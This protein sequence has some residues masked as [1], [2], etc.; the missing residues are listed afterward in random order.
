[1]E[2]LD[3]HQWLC[4]FTQY[5]DKLELYLTENNGCKTYK[6]LQRWWRLTYPQFK[7]KR[8]IKNETPH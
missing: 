5:G 1:M 8:A 3:K 7:L 4:C 2:H 6:Q